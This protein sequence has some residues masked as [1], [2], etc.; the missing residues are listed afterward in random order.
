MSNTQ[1]KFN[2]EISEV[3]KKAAEKMVQEGLNFA[4]VDM[5]W[6]NGVMFL[7]KSGTPEFEIRKNDVGALFPLTTVTVGQ[8][9]FFPA[10][11]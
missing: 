1:V 6:A 9:T 5:P 7:V 3:L 11:R 10:R 8:E 4:Q 2:E